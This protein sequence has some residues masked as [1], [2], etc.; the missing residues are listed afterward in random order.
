VLQSCEDYFKEKP[1]GVTK[2]ILKETVHH[3]SFDDRG[4]TAGVFVDMVATLRQNGGGK[5]VIMTRPH[6]CSH[7]PFGARVAQEWKKGQPEHSLY[8]NALRAAGFDNVVTRSS[9]FEINMGLQ[10]WCG[11]VRSR[12]WSCYRNV[13]DA[14]LEED[15]ANLTK[16]RA[17]AQD[18]VMVDKLLFIIATVVSSDE[19]IS[20]ASKY[21]GA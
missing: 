14:E 18:L 10:D 17:G 11:M 12:F 8:V 21:L 9:D 15:L 3:L 4:D 1:K 2:A 16:E 7:F 19:R 5:L 20:N 13:S 6:D